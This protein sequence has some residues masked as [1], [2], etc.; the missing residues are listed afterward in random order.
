[1]SYSRILFLVPLLSLCAQ[2]QWLHYPTARVPHRPDGLPDL[3]AP[4]PRAVDGKPDLSGIWEDDDGRPW[5][6][7]AKG[8]CPEP[9][10]EVKGPDPLAGNIGWVNF[11]ARLP[12]GQIGRAHV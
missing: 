4:A 8:R 10:P 11:G 2:A 5:K 9:R 1:M 7:C 3:F 6:L 12:E